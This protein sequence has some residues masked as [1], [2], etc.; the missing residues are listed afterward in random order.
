MRLCIS[1]FLHLSMIS[2]NYSGALL[3]AP[4]RL[5]RFASRFVWVGGYAA[6]GR[7]SSHPHKTEASH[8][9]WQG[10]LNSYDF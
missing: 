10:Y 5:R 2:G 4:Q 9:R 6:S 7:I 1:P 3:Q 8:R